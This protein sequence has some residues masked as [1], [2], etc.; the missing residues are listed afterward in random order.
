MKKIAVFPGS[1]DPFTIGH[2]A[3]VRRALILF[4]EIIIA[5]G[6]N[7]LKKN[8][9]S[10]STRKEMINLVFK[11]EP[12][13]KISHYEGLTVDY[14]SRNN[15]GFLLRGLRTAADFEFERAIAQVNKVLAPDIESVFLLTVPEHSHI[16]STIVRD[17]IRSGGDASVFI[18]A[19]IDLKNFRG[20]E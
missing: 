14:C 20:E 11:D 4:D 10:L 3:I 12:R 7:A 18:P 9:Y 2:E 19:A 16:N 17:I 1:F 15:I 5:V 13:V 8:Y 6:A